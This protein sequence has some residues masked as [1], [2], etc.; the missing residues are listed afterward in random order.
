[1][2]KYKDRPAVVAEKMPPAWRDGA[3]PKRID[4]MSVEM[5]RTRRGENSAR[6]IVPYG[7]DDKNT[8]RA[9]IKLYPWLRSAFGEG[10]KVHR[11][12]DVAN[13]TDLEGRVDLLRNSLS[14]VEEI[15]RFFRHDCESGRTYPSACVIDVGTPAVNFLEPCDGERNFPAA[16]GRATGARV[17]VYGTSDGSDARVVVLGNVRAAAAAARAARAVAASVARG[18]PYPKAVAVAIADID[19]DGALPESLDVETSPPVVVAPKKKLDFKDVLVSAPAPVT[20][21]PAPVT[22]APASVLQ[23]APYPFTEMSSAAACRWCRARMRRVLFMPCSHL[24]LCV[25]CN[26]GHVQRGAGCA[27]CNAPVTHRLLVFLE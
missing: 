4:D 19:G 26:D 7:P 3:E 16:V 14:V 9:V 12:H 18:V 15:S 10:L 24:A 8:Y 22:T 25:Q 11:A 21:A 27:I 17:H 6:V 5:S 13:G 23:N 2:H 1:M 20:T